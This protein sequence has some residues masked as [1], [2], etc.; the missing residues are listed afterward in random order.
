MKIKLVLMEM[1]MV[2]WV[3]ADN[4]DLLKCTVF[5]G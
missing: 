3:F 2:L 1:L 5:N 4:F